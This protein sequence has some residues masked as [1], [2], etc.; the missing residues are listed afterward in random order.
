MTRT[1]YIAAMQKAQSEAIARLFEMLENEISADALGDSEKWFKKL[2][3]APIE[4][5]MNL[6]SYR[7]K[8]QL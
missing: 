8:L 2:R 3:N 5:M 4:R 1:E 6:L 7:N